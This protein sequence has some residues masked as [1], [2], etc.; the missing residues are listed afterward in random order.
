MSVDFHFKSRLLPRVIRL[1]ALSP[2]LLVAPWAHGETL[3]DGVTRTLNATTPLD[4]WRLINAASLTATGAT[5]QQIRAEAN[6]TVNL[7]GTSVTAEANRDGV[8]LTN[9]TGSVVSSQIVGGS[10]ANGVSLSNGTLSVAGSSI[11]AGATGLRMGQINGTGA[12]STAQVSNSTIVGG[13]IG[14]SISSLSALTLQGSHVTGGTAEGIRQFGSLSAAQ[15]TITGATVGISMLDDPTNPGAGVLTLDGS[16]VTGQNGAAIMVGLDGGVVAGNVKINVLN[17][18]TLVGSNGVM[19]QLNGASS[20][21]MGV[22]G[23]T[24]TG[25]ILAKDSSSL[26]LALDNS[27]MTGDVIADAAA[28]ADVGLRNG[29]EL[30]GRLQNVNSLAIDS[31]ARW[32]MVEDSTLKSLSLNGG[33]IRFGDAQAYHT[34]T[35]GDLSGKGVFEMKTDFVTGQTDFLEVTGTASGAHQLLVSSSGQDPLNA[36]A[37]RVVHTA[38]GDATFSLV[39][40]AVDLG[41]WSYG[42]AQK[43]DGTG[44][45]WYLDPTS[46]VISP[47]TQSVLALFNTA[48]TVLY[49]EMSILRNRM[50]ELRLQ[51]DKAG[52]WIRA[53]GNKYNVSASSGLGYQQI[54]QGFSLGA[55]APL[56]VGDGQWLAGV[57]AGHSNSDLDLS[58][59]T[60]GTVKSYYLGGYAT[61]LDVDSGYYFDSVLKFNRFNNESKVSLSDGQRTNGDYD[62]N[63]VSASLE[64]GR[65]IALGDG[66]FVEPYTQVMGAVIQGKDYDLDNGLQAEGDRTRSLLGKLG[67][68]AGRNF[69][70]GE[71]RTLQ[72]YVRVAYAREFAKNNNVQVNNNTFNNDLSG[73]RGELGTGLALSLNDKWQV[74]ADF[75]Y[76]N[77]EHI[78]QPWGGNFGVRYSW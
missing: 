22:Q 8:A 42:L 48:P 54:Q 50:G 57:M 34:L 30:T 28:T 13:Q 20:A 77:G 17:G 58:R 19:A 3:V 64:F 68:T 41:T 16:Q 59:G 62:N 31:Q 72:P 25:N 21:V 27:H 26:N 70:L 51:D 4:S 33:N 9:S 69:D 12:G 36:E 55:D 76:A 23:S 18:S 49:G 78:E 10:A 47:G 44:S 29:A 56:P 11:Q 46:K 37:V 32:V 15:S 74:H 71:G 35:V 61:W 2:L 1:A 5:T 24:L 53:Y 45:D 67:T 63:A 65:H 75:D 66:Y 52:G 39:N 38:S 6:S 14:A 43:P 73:S 40:G 7:T 60:S